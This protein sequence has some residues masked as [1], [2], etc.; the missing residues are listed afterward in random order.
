[1]IYQDKDYVLKQGIIDI[2]RTQNFPKKL[3]FFTP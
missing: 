2:V 1:M 3:K